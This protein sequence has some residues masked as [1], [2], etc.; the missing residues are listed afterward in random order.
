[1]TGYSLD[2]YRGYVENAFLVLT[3]E[4][5]AEKLDELN[6]AILQLRRGTR[7]NMLNSE[8]LIVEL[9]EYIRS[10]EIL[11]DFIIDGTSH[12]ILQSGPN[13]VGYGT[14]VSQCARSLAWLST[15]SIV[16]ESITERAGTYEWFHACFEQSPWFLFSYLLSSVTQVK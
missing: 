9:W 14:L 15:T 10:D 4:L 7:W 2:I 1:M 5:A 12:F 16:D 8:E 11:N 6:K 3:A 13:S